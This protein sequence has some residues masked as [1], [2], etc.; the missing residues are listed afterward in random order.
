[1][2]I[3]FKTVHITFCDICEKGFT[4]LTRMIKVAI[5]LQTLN[6]IN[7]KSDSNHDQANFLIKDIFKDNSYKK[8][9]KTGPG[10]I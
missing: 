9:C 10:H 2:I 5:V 7:D 4:R 3:H 1:M 6:S 8:L